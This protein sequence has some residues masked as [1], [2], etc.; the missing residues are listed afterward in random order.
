MLA[1]IRVRES[2]TIV[3]LRDFGPGKRP[4]ASLD[5]CCPMQG[6]HANQRIDRPTIDRTTVNEQR[7][8]QT[9]LPRGLRIIDP[10]R[11]IFALGHI[12]DYHPFAMETRVMSLQK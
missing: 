9:A 8:E 7:R 11:F 10:L 1:R 4:R 5:S 2:G 12:R 6:R 3:S